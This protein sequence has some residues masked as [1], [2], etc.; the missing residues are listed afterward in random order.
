MSPGSALTPPIE[1]VPVIMSG[2]SGTR[3]WPL[4]TDARP[5][6]FHALAGARTMLQETALRLAVDGDIAFQSPVVICNRS[7]ERLIEAQLSEV[8]VRPLAIVLEPFGRN[9]AAVAVTAAR[10]V[11]S[12][13]PGALALLLPADHVIADSA[14]FS[15]AVARG[16]QAKG[17]IVTF[18][19]APTAP[20]TGYGYI[21]RAEPIAEGVFA[22]ARFAEKPRRELAEAYLA[23]GGYDWNGGIFLFAPEVMLGEMAAHRPDIHSAALAAVDAAGRDGVFVRLDDERFLAIPSASVDVA[24]MERTRLAAVCPCDIGWADVGSWSELWRLGG[25]D[26]QDNLIRGDAVALDTHGSLIWSDDGMEIG[27]VGLS[28]VVVVATPGAVIVLPKDRAQE[29]RTIVERLRAR[30][31]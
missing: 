24:V 12:L 5:K 23:N 9:T 18:G 13:K 11:Q 21:Q 10:V 27:V 31:R 4:S 2:G 19:I 8:G 7:H 17:R 22:V 14:A 29:V 25:K 20:E 28:D 1:V 3:L 6:Q 15:A 26:G 30:R 16:V